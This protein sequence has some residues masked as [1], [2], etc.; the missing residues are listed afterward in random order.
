MSNR[1]IGRLDNNNTVLVFADSDKKHLSKITNI[2]T[3]PAIADEKSRTFEVGKGLAKDEWFYINLSASEKKE[4]I[5]SYQSVANSSTGFNKISLNDYKKLT[6]L[7][8]INQNKKDIIFN[9]ISAK[10]FIEA[11]TFLKIDV[12]GPEVTKPSNIV[13]F[14]ANVDAYWHEE[15]SNLY[16]KNF[17]V[18][19]P[20]FEGIEKFYRSASKQETEQF[21]KNDFFNIQKDFRQDKVGSRALSNIAMILDDKK[22]D[23]TDVKVRNKYTKYAKKFSEYGINIVNGKFDLSTPADLTK[24]INILQQRLYKAEVTGE[25]RV[26]DHSEALLKP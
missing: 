25:S 3:F 8:L 23:F 5:D 18:I 4:M 6:C 12:N 22:I 13:E 9:R 10:Y 17:S 21:L 1:F 19:K 11:K 16:F 26:A 20:L 15:S 7:Y 14:T 2:F 24:V